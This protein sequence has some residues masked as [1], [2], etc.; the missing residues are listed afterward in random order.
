MKF[1][2]MIF[3]GHT[4]LQILLEIQKLLNTLVCEP[5]YFPG[6]IIFMS[7]YNDIDWGDKDNERICSA[8]SLL[9]GRDARRFA[10]GRWSVL[11]PS[12]ETKWNVTDTVKLGAEW[13]RVAELMLSNLRESRH[14][15]FRATSALDR[16][17]LKS[18]GSGTLPTH[19]CAD[20][21]TIQTFFRTSASGNQLS[22]YGAVA[23]LCEEFGNTLAGKEKT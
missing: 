9:V 23:D 20:Y 18:K 5:E 3:P 19:F 16:G 13:D 21:A 1:E 12:S 10:L 11:G 7:M 14:T 17:Q 2:W 15:I 22:I 6:R 8:N 4:T